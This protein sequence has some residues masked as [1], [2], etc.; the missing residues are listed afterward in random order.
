MLHPDQKYELCRLL[1][2]ERLHS[3]HQERLLPQTIRPSWWSFILSYS[4][5]L[6]IAIGNNLKAHAH[7]QLVNSHM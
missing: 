2:Q 5:E 4:G 3:I 1:Q 7:P 6:F